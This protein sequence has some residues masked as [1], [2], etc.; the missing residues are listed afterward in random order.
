[1]ICKARSSAAKLMK[2]APCRHSRGRGERGACVGEARASFVAHSAAADGARAPVAAEAEA[3]AEAG[4]PTRGGE[5]R[6]G[7]GG[8]MPRLAKADGVAA[9]ADVVQVR[10]ESVDGGAR[11]AG[12]V[13]GAKAGAKVEVRTKVEGTGRARGPG[14]G[15]DRGT[16]GDEAMAGERQAGWGGVGV[17]V[18]AVRVRLDGQKGWG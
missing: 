12:A 15:A 6:V 8:G 16:G 14:A 4:A 3:E 17:G 9:A 5:S 2:L 18:W 7:H 11:G 13:A 1:M 10:R